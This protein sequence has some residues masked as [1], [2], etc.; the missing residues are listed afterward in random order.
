[1]IDML[2]FS[3]AMSKTIAVGFTMQIGEFPKQQGV[4]SN[5]QN[6]GYLLTHLQGILC[7]IFCINQ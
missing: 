2:I 3:L 4:R 5:L 6:K 7:Y 1:M